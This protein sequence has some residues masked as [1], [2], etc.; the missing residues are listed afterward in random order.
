MKLGSTSVCLAVLSVVTVA[1]LAIRR[2]ASV[3]S[4]LTGALGVPSFFAPARP[5]TAAQTVSPSRRSRIEVT[6]LSKPTVT[7]KLRMINGSEISSFAIS[8]DGTVDLATEPSLKH[9]MH[10][11]RTGR[12]LPMAA[13]VLAMLTSV[14]EQWPGQVIDIVSAFRAPPFGVPHSKHFIGHAIDLRVEGVKTTKLRDFIWRTHHEVG[15]GYYLNEDFVHMD[16]RPGEPD[17]AWSAG[18]EGDDADYNPRWAWTARHPAGL[19]P[20]E[21]GCT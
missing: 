1:D 13:G 14:A 17:M 12:E 9:F 3:F 21:R 16:W 19:R 7:V 18:H 15:V 11:R 20:C 2:D 4:V 6:P 5:A 10:C 8:K